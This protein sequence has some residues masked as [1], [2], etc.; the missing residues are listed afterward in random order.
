MR[1]RELSTYTSIAFVRQPK[2]HEKDGVDDEDH[3][4]RKRASVCNAV[5]V[6]FIHNRSGEHPS[7][8]SVLCDHTPHCSYF[9]IR[10]RAKHTCPGVPDVSTPTSSSFCLRQAPACSALT[11]PRKKQALVEAVDVEG[12]VTVEADVV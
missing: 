12:V 2:R 8:L 10:S 3:R 6:L 9:I 1:T 7:V 11:Q 5:N 4:R